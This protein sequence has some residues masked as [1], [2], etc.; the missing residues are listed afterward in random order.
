MIEM[1]A[2]NATCCHN[3]MKKEA[4]EVV[5]NMKPSILHLHPLNLYILEVE[6]HALLNMCNRTHHHI[7]CNRYAN[8]RH[9][10]SDYHHIVF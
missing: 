9:N 1:L 2:E 7:P 10:G 6:F 5:E 3:N 4:Q 8:G